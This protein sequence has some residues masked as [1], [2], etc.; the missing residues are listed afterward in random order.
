MNHLLEQAIDVSSKRSSVGAQNRES[1]MLARVQNAKEQL[2]LQYKQITQIEISRMTGMAVE[3]MR[4]YPRIKEVLN[5]VIEEASSERRRRFQWQEE[6]WVYQVD[7]TIE[8]LLEQNI[9]VTQESIAR[10]LSIA[11]G[12]LKHYPKVKIILE[13]KVKDA[14]KRQ[15]QERQI[16]IIN[17]IKW[18][19]QMLKARRMPISENAIAEELQIS[20]GS[21]RYY[22]EAWATLHR[23]VKEW[24]DEEGRTRSRVEKMVEDVQAYLRELESSRQVISYQ[25]ISNKLEISVKT[26]K[27]HAQTREIIDRTLNGRAD[28]PSGVTIVSPKAKTES[29]RRKDKTHRLEGGLTM[30]SAT[31]I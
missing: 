10:H 25:I 13:Q 22:L 20:V 31:G 11:R 3:N 5:K 8:S 18:A 14:Q 15:F 1:N 30:F 16:D 12:A 17:K 26:L 24:T 2:K 6:E 21:L 27:R 23:A 4:R 9:K 19:A 28:V 29:G 7:S